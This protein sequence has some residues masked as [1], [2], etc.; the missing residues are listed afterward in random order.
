M[1]ASPTNPQVDALLAR[2]KRLESETSGVLRELRDTPEVELPGPHLVLGAGAREVL[3]SAA[4]V[5]EIARA[6]ALQPV[7]GAAPAVAGSFTYRG[8][9]RFAVE[10]GAL[11]ED[12]AAHPPHLESHLV[13]LGTSRPLALLVDRVQAVVTGV[14][15]VAADAGPSTLSREGLSPLMARHGAKVAPLLDATLLDAWLEGKTP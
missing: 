13:L 5:L 4:S 7:A 12:R 1:S 6:V 11:L 8:R 9:A 3:L 15:L 2:L 10:L 14:R